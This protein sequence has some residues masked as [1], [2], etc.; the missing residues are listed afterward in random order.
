MPKSTHLRSVGI[1]QHSSLTY[2]TMRSLHLPSRVA[3][4]RDGPVV[5]R[6]LSR[7]ALQPKDQFSHVEFPQVPIAASSVELG[8]SSSLSKVCI[9]T[10]CNKTKRWNDFSGLL[11]SSHS[12]FRLHFSLCQVQGGQLDRRLKAR[13]F[14]GWLQGFLRAAGKTVSHVITEGEMRSDER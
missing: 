7:P 5:A 11:R 3:G 9:Y 4:R 13:T 14:S 2:Q 6:G 8:G 10:H 1:I 12:A